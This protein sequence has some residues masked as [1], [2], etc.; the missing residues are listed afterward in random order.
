VISN[1]VGFGAVHKRRPQTLFCVCPDE[2]PVRLRN[3]YASYF[4][5]L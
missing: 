2:C 3:V 1:L 5:G 4:A